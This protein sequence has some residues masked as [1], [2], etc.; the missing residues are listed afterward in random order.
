MDITDAGLLLDSPEFSNAVAR[1]HGVDVDDFENSKF[2]SPEKTAA[3]NFLYSGTNPD[4]TKVTG[5]WEDAS[6]RFVAATHGEVRTLVGGADPERVFATAE[7]HAL[8]DNPNITHVDGIPAEAL[9]ARPESQIFEAVRAQSEAL[10]AHLKIAV[11]G[12]GNILK[13]GEVPRIDTRDFFA[14]TPGITGT[15]PAIHTPMRSMAELIPPDRIS[16]YIE[17]SQVLREIRS[18]YEDAMRHTSDLDLKAAA[19][20]ALDRIGIAGDVLA[21]GLVAR[22][23]NAAHAEGDTATAYQLIRDWS[24]EFLGGLAGGLLAA[25]LASA[26]LTPV[27]LTGPVGATIAGALTLASGFAGA[28]VGGDQFK[29]WVG[30]LSDTAA[31]LGINATVGPTRLDPLA[32][33]LDGDGLETS[34]AT[35]GAVVLFDHNA[36]GIKA[37]T[38]WLTPDDGW[39]AMDRNYNGTIDSGRELFGVDTIKNNGTLATDGFDALKDLD[40]NGDGRIDAQDTAFARLR[41][42]R[43]MNQDGVSQ[44]SELST[45][46]AVGIVAINLNPSATVTNLGNGNFQTATGSFVRADGSTGATGQT[47]GN[48]ANLE[49]AVNTFY[50]EFTDTIAPTDQASVLPDMQGSG[51]V[52][53]LREAASLSPELSEALH[54]YAIESTRDAQLARL[55]DLIAQ[56]AN[57]SDMLSLKMQADALAAQGVTLSYDLPSLTA[58]PAAR[59]AFIDKLGVVERFMGFTYGTTGGGARFTALSAGEGNVS[60]RMVPMQIESVERAYDRI[61]ADMYEALLLETRLRPYYDQIQVT[62]TD[63]IPALDLSGVAAAFRS[64]IQQ[65]R[66]SGV[67]DMI[68]FLSVLGHRSVA[69]AA[70][71]LAALV[72]AELEGTPDLGAYTNDLASWVLGLAATAQASPTGDSVAELLVTSN[73]ADTIHAREGNDVVIAR[74]GDD[75]VYGGSGNDTLSGGAG[76]DALVGGYGS[77]TLVFHR[78]D[79]HDTVHS[80]YTQWRTGDVDTLYFAD[81]NAANIIVEGRAQDLVFRFRDMEGGE[82]AVSE[83]DSVTVAGYLGLNVAVIDRVLFADGVQWDKASLLAIARS[84]P[85]FGTSGNDNFGGF[86]GV[87][88]THFGGDGNDS[89]R[90]AYANDLLGGDAGHDDLIGFTGNDT[91]IGGTGNDTLN[92][93]K[94]S[95]TVVYRRGDGHDIVN[96]TQ[97]DRGAGDIDKLQ[98]PDLLPSDLTFERIGTDLLIRVTEDGGTI[99]FTGMLAGANPNSIDQIVFADGTL[100]SRAHLLTQAIPNYGTANNDTVAGYEGGSNIVYSGDGNDALHGASSGDLLDGGNG[101]DLLRGYAGN[102]TL[103]GAA[104]VDTLVGGTGSDRFIYRRG[105]GHDIINNPGYDKITGDVDTLQLSGIDAADMGFERIGNDLLIRIGES[106]V[107]GSAGNNSNALITDSIR[108]TGMLGG[109]S[110]ASLDQ[111]VFDD[112]TVWSR[113][114]LLAQAIPFYG[115]GGNDWLAAYS[116]SPNQ[117]FGLDG[118]DTL[119][120][121]DGNDL[122]NGGFGNDS[123][124]GG[125]GNDVLH[126]AQGNDTL[127]GSYGSDTFV[128]QRGDGQDAIINAASDKLT[129]DIDKLHLPD[130]NPSNLRFERIGSDLLISV[131]DSIDT[132][133]ITGLLGGA[134]TKS[135]DQVSFADGTV[136]TRAQLLAQEIS[137]YGTAGNDIL[138]GYSGSPNKMNGLAGDDRLT[139]NDGN[140]LLEGGAGNDTLNGSVGNDVLDGGIGADSLSG[141]YGSDTFVFRRGDGQDVIS[142]TWREKQAQDIDTLHLPD[143]DPSELR[144]ERIGNDLWIRVNDSADTIRVV[145]FLGGGEANSLDRFTFGNGV[146]LTRSQFLAQEIPLHGTVGN[147]ILTGYS[148]GPNRIFAGDGND[149]IVA[150]DGNDWLEGGHGNDTISGHFGNDTLLGGTGNDSLTGSYGSDTIVLRRGDGEDVIDNS[151]Y[152]K[153]TG[154]IDTLEWVDVLSSE[155]GFERSGNDLLIRV[156][157][158]ADS[159]RVKGYLGGDN[160]TS[161]DRFVFADGSAW[162]RAELLAR[163]IP[164]DGSDGS[165]RLTGYYGA[166]NWI[167]GKAGN[168]TIHGGDVQDW[169]A[170]DAGNDFLYGNNGNDTLTGG[171]GSDTLTGGFGSD[172]IIVRRG[173]GQDTIDNLSALRNASDIDTLLFAD[174]LSPDISLER[175]GMDLLIHTGQ[176]G[177]RVSIL[178]YLEGA[179]LNSI[180]RVEFADGSV[181]DKSALLAQPLTTRGAAGNDTLKASFAAPNFLHG[182]AG[183]DTIT[184]GNNHDYLQGGIGNDSLTGGN[185][186]DVLVGGDGADVLRDMGATGGQN[187]LSG[188]GGNDA[189]HGGAGAELFAGGTGDDI[190]ETGGGSDVIVFNGG[191]GIDTVL[192]GAG[193]DNTVSL[194]G[195]DFSELALQ[196]SG[197]DLHLLTGGPDLLKFK[198]WFLTLEH[199]S[200]ALLQLIHPDENGVAPPTVSSIDFHELVAHFEQWQ[201][202]DASTAAWVLA[203][204]GGE[205]AVVASAGQAIGGALAV[206]Y[207]ANG[208]TGD[209]GYSTAQ[210]VLG[211]AGFGAQQQGTDFSDT[212]LDLILRLA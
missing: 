72:I 188:G 78:G 55:D 7:V 88:A 131:N 103:S 151:R 10:S 81:R 174:I 48:V 134:S 1:V 86:D 190:I 194:G 184:G 40:T 212:G 95:D 97:L 12:D 14:N 96:N 202:I 90:G 31:A 75:V 192:A 34:G 93:G 136:W 110:P 18:S 108:V 152:E 35:A 91:L 101:N 143:L 69:N 100:W 87:A 44:S 47:V 201:A 198:D 118:N 30:Q 193:Q 163:T 39:I 119:M 196:K 71:D 43:D 183:N 107:V 21:L 182:E 149:K 85:N 211:S 61:K 179:N 5:V 159:V 74:A 176:D 197:N 52:R 9:R 148:G 26:A 42:W 157:G 32:I 127:T 33:D 64:A 186:N 116:G 135:I 16:T 60:V 128:F 158:G 154:D 25:K 114:Q 165:D 59:D 166:S 175:S 106:D 129:G 13:V 171:T 28:V 51:R 132:I 79:G 126:G 73:L 23:A 109:T 45:L 133:K 146:S 76:A 164:Y 138:T 210:L 178:G 208:F 173:D 50:R 189:I 36:D 120:G 77:D 82:A 112:G 204:D 56:W 206:E 130:L 145:N 113:A 68:E 139:G 207:A 83:N 58:T 142:N 22:A 156:A 57:T 168:D 62:L 141:S 123:L 4:G 102:D 53:D 37:G 162:T 200:V 70:P 49:L 6:V 137:F 125:R 191:D 80:H 161:L 147:D 205:Q 150:A 160:A 153:S 27:Y 17:G 122:L 29:Q 104:G 19:H 46:G 94:G 209:A 155:L 144:Y 124:N 121:A 2:S 98:L 115:T 111:L 20:K 169:L 15:D 181:W 203:T 84:A 3:N 195:I 170:G 92:S 99:R 117:L 180:N 199:R 172:T 89:V 185:G 187:L 38:G 66:D 140:D 54:G 177:D 8:R 105:D 67:I 24:A 41:V 11:D 63:G 65:D 167:S